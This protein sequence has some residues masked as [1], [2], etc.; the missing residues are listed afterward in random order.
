MTFFTRPYQSA[1]DLQLIM[2]L[3][4]L[5]PADRILDYP[6]LV[7][8][9]ELLASRMIQAATRLW[10][11]PTGQFAGYA[12]INF[13]QMFAT[14]AFEYKPEFEATEIG[15]EMVAWG[16]KAFVDGYQGESDSL[17]SDAH[18]SYPERIG[19]L[20]KHGFAREAW[21]GLHLERALD[22]PIPDPK[23]PQGFIIRPVAGK[24][25]DAAWV[26]L[27]QAA[28]GTQNMTLEV[29]Q[30]M[31]G[32]AGYDR[33]L[34]LVAVGPDG[35]LAAYV[36]GWYNLEDNA[37]C[38]RKIGFTDPIGTH[39]AYQRRGLSRALLLEAL[40]RLKHR[41][42]DTARLGTRSLNLAM[43]K[44]AQSVGFSIVDEIWRFKKKL[45]IT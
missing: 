21:S 16:E 27:H 32:V 3:F 9:Q 31:T 28:F 13:G 26:G 33:D 18:G 36:F 43:Q 14:L 17:S 42:L 6:I 30:S 38:G 35:I 23:I 25:E 5:R 7:D 29:R 22:Q 2:D 39:P 40:H 20:E 19:L 24:S 10:E 8:F 4:K 37:W 11:T 1:T 41:G 45:G 15:D 12:L 44:T 34:D